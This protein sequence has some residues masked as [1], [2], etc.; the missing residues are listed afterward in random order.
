MFTH[1]I[2][3]LCLLLLL[4]NTFLAQNERI[5]Q[6]ISEANSEIYYSIESGLDKA[7]I[8]FRLSESSN[9][10]YGKAKSLFLLGKTN[11]Y[12]G[13]NK[14][15]LN[16]FKA[17]KSLFVELADNR[18]IADNLI[19][20][21]LIK[22]N[23]GFYDTALVLFNNALRISTEQKYSK[24][25]CESYINIAKYNHTKGNFKISIE[26]NKKA[27]L[28][29]KNQ[30]LTKLATQIHNNLGKD[31]EGEGNFVLALQ[32]YFSAYNSFNQFKDNEIKGTTCNH[33]GSLYRRLGNNEKALKFHR[34]ALE[35]RKQINYK[36]G[37]GKSLKNAA[38]IYMQ[39]GQYE[40]AQPYLEQALIYFQELQY[41]KG[42]TK[43]LNNL[44][45]IYE[46][47]QLDERAL[48]AYNEALTISKELG[49]DKGI[50]WAHLSLG[51]YYKNKQQYSIALR[52]LNSSLVLAHKDGLKDR[53]K[54]IYFALYE[55]YSATGQV[56]KALHYHEKFA[57]IKDELLDDRKNEHIAEMQVRLEMEKKTRE[58]KILSQKNEIQE[59]ELEQKDNIILLAII[60]LLLLSGFIIL[61]Y[62]RFQIKKKANIQLEKLNKKLDKAN[63]AKDKFFSIIAHEIR[64][65]LWWFRNLATMLSSDFEKMSH[66]QLRKSVHSIDETA[67]NTFH[68]MDNLLQ[69]SRSQLNRVKFNPQKTDLSILIQENID[70]AKSAAHYKKVNLLSEIDTN[71]YVH[72]DSDLL[73]IIL[74]NLISNALKYTHEKG[75]VIIGSEK[76]NGYMQIFVKDNG[77]GITKNNLHKLFS[78]SAQYTTLGISQEKGSGLGLVLCKEFTEMHGGKI[79]TESNKGEGTTFR[80]TLP[81][82]N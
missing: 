28:I 40:V 29:A 76:A 1:I 7:R 77:I 54:E 44:G 13:N 56:K 46:I 11:I 52:N 51:I 8:S 59:L 34:D 20:I 57:V 50:I 71:T 19:Q 10:K 12:E 72:A 26:Y 35:Y 17:S 4:P 53:I 25:I 5:D 82:D 37:I 32:N 63:Q 23:W 3:L 42:I 68:L 31:Y 9:Y 22:Y 38:E 14:A 21:G 43:C 18:G 70:L 78:E 36:E 64:N 67:K 75:S 69:W 15:A 62:N 2:K 24:G 60:I 16:K 41:K 48:S 58:N 6:L 49:Y 79:W 47:Q 27:L 81:V 55:I 65:P 73:K 39:T 80:F 30:G 66:E 74:R 61:F 45:N 33:L